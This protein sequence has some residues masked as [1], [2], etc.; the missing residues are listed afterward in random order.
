VTYILATHPGQEHVGFVREI[1]TL[2]EVRG[3]DG[4]TV[5]LRVAIDKREL[6]DP[7]LGGA[8]TAKV[9][10]GRRSIGYV[11]FHDLFAFVQRMLFRI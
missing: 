10:C 1:S 3:A 7:Q 8:A 9:Y 4:N 6:T 11:W 5:L 2:A